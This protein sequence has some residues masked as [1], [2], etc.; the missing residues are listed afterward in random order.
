MYSLRSWRITSPSSPR[1]KPRSRAVTKRREPIPSLL[2]LAI[3]IGA[4]APVPRLVAQS[5]IYALSLSYALRAPQRVVDDSRV[6]RYTIR[7]AISPGCSA[8][9][10]KADFNRL[11]Y[12]LDSQLIVR[13]YLRRV[14]FGR[15]SFTCVLYM[16]LSLWDAPTLT[17]LTPFCG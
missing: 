11:L 10:W 7:R 14:R 1:D 2:A 13:T 8:R 9:I 17:P 6:P 3:A 4:T 12:T 16:P 15:Q 5:S